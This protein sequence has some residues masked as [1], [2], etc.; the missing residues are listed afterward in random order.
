[1]EIVRT[2]NGERSFTLY[3]DIREAFYP[4]EASKQIECF[5]ELLNTSA[6]VVKT[7]LLED[8]DFSGRSN[9]FAVRL[10]GHSF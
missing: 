1:M 6:A 4:R 5:T 3:T 10:L 9:L 2:G 8:R 7:A